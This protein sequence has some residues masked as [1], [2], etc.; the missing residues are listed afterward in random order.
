MET[1]QNV[2]ATRVKTN[3]KMSFDGS[4]RCG[5]HGIECSDSGYTEALCVLICIGLIEHL[6]YSF[7]ISC[8]L[9]LCLQMLLCFS[10]KRDTKLSF[11]LGLVF[12]QFLKNCRCTSGSPLF[13][14]PYE[15]SLVDSNLISQIY[16]YS[17][18]GNIL[19]AHVMCT[20][21]KLGAG[22][23]QKRALE[24]PPLML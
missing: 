1:V 18:C 20:I 10:L 12:L 13:Q 8:Q 17:L 2:F 16:F 11:C 4:E 14:T 21:C 7:H 22:E 6:L 5:V 9:S 24:L 23:G 3:M 15:G 19:P